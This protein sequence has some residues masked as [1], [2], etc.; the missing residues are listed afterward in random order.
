M[1]DFISVGSEASQCVGILHL[2][3]NPE[4]IVK[5]TG[6][7]RCGK[8]MSRKLI[9]VGTHVELCTDSVRI[10]RYLSRDNVT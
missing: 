2:H 5:V 3:R 7:C 8:C 10:V 4:A 9:C 1:L 6:E